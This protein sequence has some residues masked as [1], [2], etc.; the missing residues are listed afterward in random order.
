MYVLRTELQILRNYHWENRR[1]LSNFVGLS[2][3]RILKYDPG[4]WSGVPLSHMWLNKLNLCTK[5]MMR[6]LRFT[7]NFLKPCI[8]HHTG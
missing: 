3:A 6:H 1:K 2:I 7:L 4:P 5:C 8:V